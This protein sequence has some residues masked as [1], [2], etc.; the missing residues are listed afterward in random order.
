MD[1]ATGPADSPPTADLALL[2]ALRR[3]LYGFFA[4]LFVQPVEGVALAFLGSEE[5]ADLLG[6]GGCVLDALRREARE[7][8]ALDLRQEFWDLFVVPGK[9]FV[10]PAQSV[11]LD[12]REIEGERVGGLLM[13]DSAIHMKRALAAAGLDLDGTQPLPPDH[14][15]VELSLLCHLCDRERAAWE[16]GDPDAAMETRRA[17]E[18]LLGD[19]LLRWLPKL[20]ERV[21]RHAQLSF[22]PRVMDLLVRFVEEDRLQ[23]GRPPSGKKV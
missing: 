6:D 20:R 4:G 17:A 7:V 16:R 8:P 1:R 14:V 19:H 2:A 18:R 11:Y 23:L 22:Y 13:G 21:A 9:R 5:A 12:A 15:A 3:D 10:A